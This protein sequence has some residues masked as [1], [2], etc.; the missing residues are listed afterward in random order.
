MPGPE[1]RLVREPA[2]LVT[3][4][5]GGSVAGKATQPE[6]EPVPLNGAGESFLQEMMSW[7]TPEGK[8][9]EKRVGPGSESW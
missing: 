7:V 1:K 4:V 3:Q 6:V 5:H 9:V 8:R 2:R